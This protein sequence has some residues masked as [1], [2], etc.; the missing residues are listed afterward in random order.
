M[1]IDT[2]RLVC[3]DEARQP[4]D[5]A[6]ICDR[7]RVTWRGAPCADLPPPTAVDGI[8]RI[9]LAG[10]RLAAGEAGD[11]DL[12]CDLEAVTTA[13]GFELVVPDTGVV[14]HDANLRTRV[15]LQA[16]SKGT[17]PCT[18]GFA[19]LVAPADEL[20]VNVTD[21][22]PPLLAGDGT[23]VEVAQVILRNGA[24]P[25]SGPCSLT[26]SRCAATPATWA[27]PAPSS[28][29]AVGDDDWAVATAGF[30]VAL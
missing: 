15:S 7:L 20:L 28:A 17:W 9:P 11:L 1:A 4:L 14:A 13:A 18:T 25:A 22:M 6:G 24:S 10:V 5:P 16:G 27:R 2:L 21:R 26:G 19:R 23:T 3:L 12:I 8:I 29:R 30:D